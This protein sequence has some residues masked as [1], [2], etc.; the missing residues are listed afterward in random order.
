MPMIG[1]AALASAGCGDPKCMT[2]KGMNAL[3]GQAALLRVDVFQQG[4]ASCDG[5]TLAAGAG[6]AQLS[7]TF[8]PGETLRLDIAP[9]P[10]IVVLTTYAD[11]DGRVP[12]GSGCTSGTFSA[13]AGVCLPIT[14]AVISDAGNVGD[15]PSQG[16]GPAPSDG[17]DGSGPPLDLAGACMECPTS[18]CCS[19]ACQFKHSNGIG[20]NYYD[21]AGLGTPGTGTYSQQMATE[22]GQAWNTTGT[23]G[24]MTCP[25]GNASCVSVQTATECSVW[26]YTKSIAGRVDHQNSVNTCMCPTTSSQGWN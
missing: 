11:A 4:T 24:T 16:D 7:R 26:C 15:G 2:V 21:C 3:I 25:P 18:V 1:A 20:Q 10:H 22:A 13:G 6:A 8:K 14:L 17:S 23:M 9:G 19:G 12:T 5:P